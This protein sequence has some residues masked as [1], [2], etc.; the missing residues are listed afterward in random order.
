MLP[1]FSVFLFFCFSVLAKFFLGGW[2]LL[3]FLV[4]S[5][6]WLFRGVIEWLVHSYIHHAKPIP[7][8]KVR[9]K[10]SVHYMHLEH[11]RNPHDLET[12]L[13]KGRPVLYGAS[14]VFF[15]SAFFVC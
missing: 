13:F 6:F 1:L 3:D 2:A 12:L 9:I 10:T 4:I 14:F 5:G 7:V 11:H 8:L 15:T